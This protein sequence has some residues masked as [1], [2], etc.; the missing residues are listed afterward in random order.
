MFLFATLGFIVVQIDRQRKQ[1][2]Q[3][4]TGSRTEYLRYLANVR[5]GRPRGRRPAAP[6]ADLAPPRPGRAAGAGRGALP[7]LGARH[8]RPAASCTCGTACAPS[9][10]RSSWCRRRAR[11]IDQVDPAAASALH[12]LLVVHRLQPNLPASID[13]R[14]FDRIE[15]CGPEEPA[16]VAGPGD[17]L[18]GATAFHSPEHLVVAVLSLRAEPRPLGLGEVAAARPERPAVRRRRARCGWCPPRSTTSPRC[19]RPTSATG[20]GSAP[21]SARPTPHI[22][23]VIDGG[24]LPPGNHVVPPDGLHGVTVLDLPARWD[25]LEDADPAAAAVRRDD[26]APSDGRCPVHGAAAARGADPGPGR[27]VRPGHRR[28]VRP[29]AGPAAHGHVGATERRTGEITGPP[30]FM[31]LLGARRR[32]PLRPRRRPGARGPAR[33]RLRVPIG[34]RRGRRARSTSTSRSPPSRAWART[35]W[36]SARPAPASRSSCARWCSAWR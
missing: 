22:L 26:A 7:G 24:E 11:P 25:E 3:Q 31:D 9:R 23:L 6:G 4:V 13:L 12:R 1:R 15:V 34:A 20:P 27:P 21:T 8:R 28:G 10:S 17:D 29:P 18:L 16:R 36:S 33:D 32:A 19:C 2:T 14:A 35:A 30:D 5:T